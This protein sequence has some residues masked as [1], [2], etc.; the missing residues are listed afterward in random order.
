M[1][2]PPSPDRF[3]SRI[4]NARSLGC[5][6]RTRRLLSKSRAQK[7]QARHE[8]H[9]TP[10]E[11]SA[12][13]NGHQAPPHLEGAIVGQSFSRSSRGTRTSEPP[14]N[15]RDD[16]NPLPAA[17]GPFGS[18]IHCWA[19]PVALTP[20]DRVCKGSNTFVRLSITL[21]SHLRRG[22]YV[23][24]PSRSDSAI[25]PPTSGVSPMANPCPSSSTPRIKAIEMRGAGSTFGDEAVRG[26][27]W[28]SPQ[29]GTSCPLPL[30]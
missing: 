23:P 4:A 30:W 2:D 17:Q 27:W 28:Q 12:L 24:L 16:L 22:K 7:E 11:P 14:D 6:W 10:V 19:S 18:L 26:L 15:H 3:R 9:W 1:R 25:Q 5:K 20:G 21:R 29:F 8:Q 13:P